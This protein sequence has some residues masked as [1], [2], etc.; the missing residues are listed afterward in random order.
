MERTMQREVASKVEQVVKQ[1]RKNY[2]A[3]LDGFKVTFTNRGKSQ[4]LAYKRENGK[5]VAR[6]NAKWLTDENREAILV[7]L[8]PHIVARRIGTETGRDVA[9]TAVQLGAIHTNPLAGLKT[10]DTCKRTAK[11]RKWV[12]KDTLGQFRYVTT[13]IHNRIQREG[14]VYTYR[15][16]GAKINKTT[17]WSAA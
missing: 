2:G 8:V 14:V 1:A 12:Y 3:A 10:P 9:F 4:I 13:R 17:F 15:D 11:T 16:N 5:V 6:L 7:N